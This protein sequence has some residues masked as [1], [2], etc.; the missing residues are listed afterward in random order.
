MVKFTPN[1]ATCDTL[2]ISSETFSTV[3]ALLRFH[4]ALPPCTDCTSS[5]HHCALI[6]ELASDDIPP[7]CEALVRITS[8]MAKAGL[9]TLAT[10]SMFL[11]SMLPTSGG[12]RI[13][14]IAD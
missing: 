1:D 9:T 6:T 4:D 10:E 5:A 13:E 3:F 14:R 8:D 2:F 7:V 11:L 12:V